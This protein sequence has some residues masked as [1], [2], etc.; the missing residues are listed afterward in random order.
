MRKWFL[1]NINFILRLGGSIMNK[2]SAVLLTAVSLTALTSAGGLAVN[3]DTQQTANSSDI[4]LREGSIFTKGEITAS[5]S[6]VDLGGMKIDSSGNTTGTL[7]L[8]YVVTDTLNVNLGD[9]TYTYFAVP[10]EFQN[11]MDKL[12]ADF[13]QYIGGKFTYVPFVG[14][15]EDVIYQPEDI[16]VVGDH[17]IRVDNG[18]HAG[19]GVSTATSEIAI[20]LGKAVTN[21]KVRIPDATSV[22]KFH[23]TTTTTDALID[24]KVVGS[25]DASTILANIPQI[26]PGY[27]Y[28]DKRPVVN[29]IYDTDTKVTGEGIPGATIKVYNNDGVVIGHG[30]V[31]DDKSY[32]V[33]IDS[34]YLPLVE[35]DEI[36]VTQNAGIG[37]SKPTITYVQH[38]GNPS[39]SKTN[40]QTGYWT[41]DQSDFVVEGRFVNSAFDFGK[42]EN[43]NFA[44]DLVNERGET[45]YTVSGATTDWYT[46][47][48]YDG[49]QVEFPTSAL[50]NS[51][52]LPS[53][54]YTLKV[55]TQNTKGT[56]SATLSASSTKSLRYVLHHAWNEIESKTLGGRTITFTTGPNNEALITIK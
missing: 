32:S 33:K 6:I 10:T 40:F 39:G 48:V 56:D 35:D 26:D 43:T 53:G 47:G 17:L 19:I 38:K 41:D 22:Y 45:K 36:H 28:E 16:K 20:N 14:A 29:D 31:K 8:K 21:S 4:K 2:V 1:F 49:Y 54:T 13:T 3:A 18:R 52:I 23:A 12:G 11:L 37:E 15:S 9:H 7:D 30:T 55:R 44:A 50:S 5:G 27:G 25:S 46:A 34:K 42:K 24:W 51:S